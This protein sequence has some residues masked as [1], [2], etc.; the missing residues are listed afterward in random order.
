M[1]RKSYVAIVHGTVAATEGLI[2]RPLGKDVTSAVAIKDC[3][4]DDGATAV[5]RY[6]LLSTWEASRRSLAAGHLEI[7]RAAEALGIQ[8]A[9]GFDWEGWSRSI[10]G[11]CFSCLAVD[12]LS[13]RKHQI[14]IHL[15]SIGHPIVGDKL[16]G[17]DEQYYLD[18]VLGRLKVDAWK[19]LMLPFH[20]LHAD[21][22][23]FE[24]RGQ[25]WQFGAPE[26]SW[27]ANFHP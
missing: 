15:A 13:G 19:R 16:Y 2:E 5:T 25:S 23:A 3:V 9:E 8:A 22:I 20:A 7:L 27:L 6:R 14:R 1:I 12:P 10:E 18:F 21:R 4:R 24:W 26:E 11:S 17:F